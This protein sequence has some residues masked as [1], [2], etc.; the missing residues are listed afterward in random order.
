[1]TRLHLIGGSLDAV[2]GVADYTTLLAGAL[3]SRG[4]TAHI[5]DATA[6]GARQQLHEA[7]MQERAPV[8]VQ[9]VPNAFGWKGANV[10]FCASMLALRRQGHDVRVMF[11]EPYFYF[12]AHPFRNGLAV[13]QRLMAAILVRAATVCYVSTEQWAR[14]LSP[15]APRGTTFVPLRIPSTVGRFRNPPRE[16]QWRSK[17]LVGGSPFLVGHFGTFGD[18]VASVLHPILEELLHEREDVTVVCAGQ[19]GESFAEAVRRSNDRVAARIMATGTMAGEEIAAVL[20]A[21]DLLIQPYPDGVTTRRTSV[22]AGIANE[23]ATVTSQGFLTENIWVESAAV[24]MAPAS[25]P[26][27]HV[28]QIVSLLDDEPE[29]RALAQRGAT[30]YDAWCSIDATVDVLLGERLAATA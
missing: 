30:F 22:M 16:C 25:E 26:S 17:L 27:A 21:C 23:V 10:R 1:M 28:R 19:G 9:Y 11:H 14:Y 15:Y 2:G 3:A 29:R 7:L 20:R 18:H 13:V 24:A 12:S 4:I 8:L 6:P 5:W